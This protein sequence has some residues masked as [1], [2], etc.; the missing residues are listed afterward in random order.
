MLFVVNSGHYLCH[1]CPRSNPTYTHNHWL[2]S[3]VTYA[4]EHKEVKPGA[5]FVTTGDRV[6]SGK[7][8]AK[9]HVYQQVA[10]TYV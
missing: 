6:C 4:A 3:Q 9:R 8:Y 7:T 1:R 2:M 10:H 5:N